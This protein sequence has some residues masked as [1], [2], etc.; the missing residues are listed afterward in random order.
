MQF[1]IINLFKAFV[2]I[3]NIYKINRK[4]PNIPLVSNICADFTKG[5]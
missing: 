1:S 2:I 5:I 4:F 3:Q